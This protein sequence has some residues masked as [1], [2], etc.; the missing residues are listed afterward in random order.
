MRGIRWMADILRRSQEATWVGSAHPVAGQQIGNYLLQ[1]QL[2]AGGHGEGDTEIS[3]TG[4]ANA[5]PA[6]MFST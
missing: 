5:N 4:L 1:E 6:S 2:G 3:K